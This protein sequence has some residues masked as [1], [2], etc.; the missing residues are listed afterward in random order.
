MPRKKATVKIH[1]AV[2]IYGTEGMDSA[3]VVSVIEKMANTVVKT[4]G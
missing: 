3:S 4:R 1:R 2:K